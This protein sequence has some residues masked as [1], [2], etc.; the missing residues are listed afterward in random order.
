MTILWDWNGTLLS[1][2]PLVVKINNEVFA[3]HGYRLTSEEEYRRIFR[4]AGRS[5]QRAGRLRFRS[6]SRR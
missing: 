6:G 2:V 5:A 3:R 1:D 4:F